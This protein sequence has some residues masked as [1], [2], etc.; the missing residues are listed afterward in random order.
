V[1]APPVTAA[2]RANRVASLIE[3]V[4]CSGFPTQLVVVIG[5]AAAGWTPM[6]DDGVLSL[7]Y[8][9]SLSFVDTALMLALIALFLR[10]RQD[11]PR[12][13]FLGGR[14]PRREAWLGLALLPAT[15]VVVAALALVIAKVAPWL[16][17][18]PEN[19]LAAMVSTRI[20][21]FVLGVTV[22]VAGGVREELQ[23][24]F[25][26]NRFERDL[27]GAVVGLLVFSAA[28]GLGHT[29]QG[30]D[31]AVLTST[32]GLLW[33]ATYLWRRSVVAPVV[34]HALFNLA[35]LLHFWVTG[36]APAGL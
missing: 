34:C 18:V 14:P 32:L 9:V 15:L 22:V 31:A 5:L 1:A 35:Q 17:N 3:V 30:W 25:V 23:R 28:F 21:L 16:R 36:P 13:V 2:R 19:P 29:I 11:D 4:L 10:W 33:G 12:A 20:D 27:G 6:R 24:A 26:L 7:R 8:V